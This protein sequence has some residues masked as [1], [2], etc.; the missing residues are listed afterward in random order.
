MVAIDAGAAARNSRHTSAAC[1]G[2]RANPVSIICMQSAPTCL[3]G[4]GFHQIQLILNF[5]SHRVEESQLIRTR[6]IKNTHFY[7]YSFFQMKV[8]T[9]YE[10]NVW[11]EF[12][13]KWCNA[14]LQTGIVYAQNNNQNNRY[15]LLSYCLCLYKCSNKHFYSTSPPWISGNNFALSTG[16]SRRIIRWSL[17]LFPV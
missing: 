2:A 6:N 17:I 4:L 11:L 9:I 5:F 3:Q 13:Y 7:V 8:F 14:F 10:M 15:F 1:A 16:A 12:L